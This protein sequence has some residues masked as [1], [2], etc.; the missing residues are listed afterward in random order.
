MAAELPPAADPSESFLG[1]DILTVS[2]AASIF[3]GHRKN[4]KMHPSAVA[5]FISAGTRRTDGAVV[6]LRAY[7]LGGRWLTSRQAVAEFLR[8]LTPKSDAGAP[9]APRGPNERRRAV[10]RAEAELS[11]YG[12]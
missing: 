12:I 8:A 10:S 1:E 11:K 2:Q 5:R 6:R 9:R 4:S 7:R 3:P